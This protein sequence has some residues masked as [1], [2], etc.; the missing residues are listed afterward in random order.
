VPSDTSPY[1]R[2]VG[3]SLGP[4]SKHRGEKRRKK[5][6]FLVERRKEGGEEWRGR[7]FPLLI[8]SSPL[9]TLDLR[10]LRTDEG[11]KG[12][13]MVGT[14]RGRG[15]KKGEK[16]REKGHLFSMYVL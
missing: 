3:R 9:F 10:P 14:K 8:L 4:L 16:G 7:L 13:K 1:W 15:E 5:R 11:G 2:A 12:K 6:N